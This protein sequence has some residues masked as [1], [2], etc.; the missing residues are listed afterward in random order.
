MH[1]DPLWPRQQYLDL[2]QE[3]NPATLLLQ[4]PRLF[5]FD[6]QVFHVGEDHI[7]HC[8]AAKSIKN[9][10]VEEK[11]TGKIDFVSKIK[12]KCQGSIAKVIFKLKQVRK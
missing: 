12:V 7:L 6:S 2:R 1:T 4:V 9:S 8:G 5:D 3:T 10:E 11:Y